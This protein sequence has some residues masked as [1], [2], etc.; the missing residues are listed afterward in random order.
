M[1]DRA[2]F[3]RWFWKLVP[4]EKTAEIFRYKS[5]FI[6]WQTAHITRWIRVVFLTHS[7]HFVANTGSVITTDVRT[8]GARVMKRNVSIHTS[9]KQCPQVACYRTVCADSA[10]LQQARVCIVLGN[11][12]EVKNCRQAEENI[13]ASTNR[14]LVPAQHQRTRKI[15]AFVSSVCVPVCLSVC[16]SML[17]IPG[18]INLS[19]RF[20]CGVW[21]KFFEIV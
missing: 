21:G 12:T 1:R 9:L 13:W 2:Q 5:G 15:S 8:R 20:A 14:C 4:E 11:R 6:C 3:M 16:L 7:G 17:D 19:P 10:H 18:L